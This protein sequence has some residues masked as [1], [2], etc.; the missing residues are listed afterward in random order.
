MQTQP[1]EENP[2]ALR[3]VDSFRSILLA[4]HNLDILNQFLYPPLSIFPQITKLMKS[5]G[6]A[7]SDL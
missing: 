4:L 5:L 2:L 3:R 7:W 1:K 6:S